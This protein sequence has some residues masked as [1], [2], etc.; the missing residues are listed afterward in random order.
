MIDYG[1][2]NVSKNIFR[3]NYNIDTTNHTIKLSDITFGISFFKEESQIYL[4]RPE[5]IT[6]SVEQVSRNGTTNEDIFRN[7]IAMN[8]C[9]Q[10]YDK[11]HQYTAQRFKIEDFKC[12]NI[13]NFILAGSDYA[14]LFNYIEIRLYK[15]NSS[16]SNV[17]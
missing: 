4:D 16:V 5:Y 3:K 9:D 17:T 6:Y 13:S 11:V 15:C 10:S 12:P 2:S 7:E 1:N 14:P 8:Q